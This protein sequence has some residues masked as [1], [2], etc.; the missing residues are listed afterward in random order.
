MI[1]KKIDL[2]I[3]TGLVLAKIKWTL[4]ITA[5][6]LL[7][8]SLVLYNSDSHYFYFSYLTSYSFYLSLTLGGMFFVLIHYQIPK[9][10]VT[11]L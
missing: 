6:V 8:I 5:I 2:N 4:F 1:N 7:L 10:I 3:K 9:G 11:K